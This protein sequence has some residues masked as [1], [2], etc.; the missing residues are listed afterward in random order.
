MKQCVTLT[1]FFGVK[2]KDLKKLKLRDGS[3]YASTDKDIGLVRAVL[4]C[5]YAG[6]I[7]IRLIRKE[8]FDDFKSNT[9]SWGRLDPKSKDKLRLMIA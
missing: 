6:I 3:T 4:R 5:L 1:D 8:D 7:P 2:P 9:F